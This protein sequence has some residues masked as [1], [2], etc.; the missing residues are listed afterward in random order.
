VA[1]KTDVINVSE[2]GA[3]GLTKGESVG[4]MGEGMKEG[5]G[6]GWRVEE[7]IEV[8]IGKDTRRVALKTLYRVR[9][10]EHVWLE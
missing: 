10:C 4:G 2:P 6:G 8:D 7:G 9:I 1:S 5:E 3:G